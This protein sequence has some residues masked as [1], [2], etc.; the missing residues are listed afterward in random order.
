MGLRTWSPHLPP[1]PHSF[2]L[3]SLG[4]QPAFSKQEEGTLTILWSCPINFADRDPEALRQY[5]DKRYTLKGRTRAQWL[6]FTL[7]NWLHDIKKKIKVFF[8]EL[9]SNLERCFL[10]CGGEEVHGG[11]LSPTSAWVS[12]PLSHSFISSSSFIHSPAL[13]PPVFLPPE[14]HTSFKSRAPR[15]VN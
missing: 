13:P 1:P 10:P 15:A 2:P 8:K 12:S 4:P 14:S 11:A 6:D 9:F 5:N 7:E 3:T